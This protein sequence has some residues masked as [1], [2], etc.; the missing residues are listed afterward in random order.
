[1]FNNR[2]VIAQA[3]LLKQIFLAKEKDYDQYRDIIQIYQGPF[4]L[5]ASWLFARDFQKE[6]VD[7]I[8]RHLGPYMRKGILKPGEIKVSPEAVK[9]KDSESFYELVPFVDYVHGQYPVAAKETKQPKTQ[10][11]AEDIP[12]A[13]GDGIKIYQI[14]SANDGRRLVGKDTDWCIGYAG[15]N[16]MWQSYRSSQ[17]STFFVVYDEKPP[18]PNQRKVAVDFTR[19][20]VQLTD[21]PN[22]TGHQLSNGMYW[23]SYSDYLRNKGVDLDATRINPETNEEKKIFQNKPITPQEQLVSNLFKLTNNNKTGHQLSNGMYWESYSDY[24]RNKGVDLDATRINPETNEEKKIFQNKPITPQEQLVS[25]LFKLTNNNKYG[26]FGLDITPEDVKMWSTGRFQIRAEGDAYIKGN[27]YDPENFLHNTPVK[28]DLNRRLKTTSISF[29]NIGGIPGFT[30]DKEPLDSVKNISSNSQDDFNDRSL[31]YKS[32][33]INTNETKTLLPKFIGMG[34]I[35]PNPVFDYI[36]ELPDSKDVLMQYVD[37]GI[38]IP[39]EQISKLQQVPSLFKTYIRKQIIGVDRGSTDLEFLEF[40]DPNDIE[41]RNKVLD[42]VY[43]KNSVVYTQPY[44]SSYKT[45]LK[46]LEVTQLGL[47][48]IDK[49]DYI[50]LKDELAVKVALAKG[51]SIYLNK[52]PTLENALIYLHDPDSINSFKAEA[53]SEK[54]Y[55]LL[56][57][58][59]FN[60]DDW[61]ELWKSVPDKL[62]NLPELNKY[63]SIAEFNKF[64]FARIALPSENQNPELLYETVAINILAGN[65]EIAQNYK[66]NPEFCLYLLNNFNK[67]G[68]SVFKNIYFEKQKSETDEDGDI[69]E[70]TEYSRENQRE[71]LVDKIKN[72][73]SE[74]IL[75]RPEIFQALKNNF[76]ETEIFDIIGS[77]LFQNENLLELFSNRF[78]TFYDAYKIPGYTISKMFEKDNPLL[79][80]ITRDGFDVDRFLINSRQPIHHIML[81]LKWYPELLDKID[82]NGLLKIVLSSNGMPDS[83]LEY[84]HQ[85]R[86][87]V[88]YELASRN[89]HN[90]LN[91]EQRQFLF[92]KQKES[93]QESPQVDEIEPTLEIKEEEPTTASVNLMVKIARKLD[94]KKKYRLADKLTYIIRKKI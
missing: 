80:K 6:Q 55:P 5:L 89:D 82:D 81:A 58:P 90:K 24:L 9:I 16:N 12:V 50:D 46:W 64:A 63:K 69:N 23:E 33:T 88:F 41:I 78:N 39:K 86:P 84:L 29:P 51:M 65:R 94:F 20:E 38:S 11:Q 54:Y 66:D 72:F 43:S 73:I 19:G 7:D 30:I 31:L 34:W 68:N 32:I 93:M 83:Y 36:L 15:P 75:I 40:V 17:S 35:L 76:S 62:K 26:N 52:A 25:N 18:T 57:E 42:A 13:T 3:E 77:K 45:P 21:I 56:M 61:E 92:K 70:L 44:T 47:Y 37:T 8:F 74:T 10:E 28:F 2:V 85:R 59:P 79:R 91:R 14:N 4:K 71:E 60:I 87:E 1:M 27:K 53:I 49:N 22:K 67:L 48:L